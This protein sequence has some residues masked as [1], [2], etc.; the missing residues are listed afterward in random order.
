MTDAAAIEGAVVPLDPGGAAVADEAGMYRLMLDRQA[1]LVTWTEDTSQ[2]GDKWGPPLRA[3]SALA[4][5]LGS[6]LDQAGRSRMLSAG[7]E[8]LF[9][10]E[11]PT[12]STINDLVP[13]LGGGFRGLVRTGG[14]AAISGHVRLHPV[15][16]VAA[17]GAGLGL[18]PAVAL[19]ALSVGCEMLARHQQDKKLRDIQSGVNA[20]VRGTEQQTRAQ[21]HAAEQAIEQASA[22]VLD[23]IQVP[24]AIGLGSARTNLRVIKNQATEWLDDWQERLQDAKVGETGIDFGVMRKVLGG[25]EGEKEYLKFPD[26]VAVLYRAL[27]LDSRAMVLTG[28]E[29]ALARPDLTLDNLQEQLARDLASNAELQARLR[30]LLWDLVAEPVSFSLPAMPNTGKKVARLSRGLIGLAQA[31]SRTPE[32][33]GVLTPANQQ[34]TEVLAAKD[35][36]LRILTPPPPQ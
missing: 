3:G 4:R 21:L 22:A 15:T 29:A 34:V 2:T 32:A 10:I 24:S 19:L 14:K 7:S 1:V 25:D 28:A 27:A 18:G 23:R 5:N 11:V 16:G 31:A 33:L 26:R 12:G 20:L 35:G 6:I 36:S 30:G 8:A 13:A 17:V 9:R